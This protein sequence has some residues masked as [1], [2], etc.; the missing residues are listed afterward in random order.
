MPVSASF[1]DSTLYREVRGLSRGLA[2]LRA[3]NAMP[4]G[5]GGVVELARVTGLHRTLLVDAPLAPLHTGRQPAR[6]D[7]TD[8]ED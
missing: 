7:R 2:V 3:L 4:G 6:T 8:W 5:I 1:G